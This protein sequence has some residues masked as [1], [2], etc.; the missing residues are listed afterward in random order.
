METLF[1]IT[2]LFH[3]IMCID[4]HELDECEF[5]HEDMMPDKWSSKSHLF[6]LVEAQR[7]QKNSGIKPDEL[8]RRMNSIINS[9][10]LISITIDSN[11]ALQTFAERIIDLQFQK[12]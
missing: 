8:L 7:F 11:P 5:Y 3:T 12:D 9:F 6:W 10:S 1:K 2:E 4:P